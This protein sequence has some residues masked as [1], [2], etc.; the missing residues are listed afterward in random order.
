MF[1]AILEVYHKGC[2]G[3]E[4]NLKFKNQEC[5]SIDVRWIGKSVVHIVKCSGDKK[6]FQNILRYIQEKTDVKNSEVLSITDHELYIR[7]STKNNPKHP[8]FSN[9]FFEK[10]CFPIAPTQFIGKYEVWTLGSAKK[11]SVHKVYQTLKKRYEVKIKLIKEE[12]ITPLLTQ[13]QREVFMYAKYFGYYEWPRKRSASD[14]AKNLKMSKTVFFSHLR[15]AEQ[16]ILNTH[17]G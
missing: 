1:K 11:E 14:I 17:H 10:H 5:S 15:K 3:S 7:V 16:K 12:Q 6:E 8:C 4:I 9:M 2:W 13:K